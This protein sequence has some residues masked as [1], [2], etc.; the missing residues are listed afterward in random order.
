MSQKAIIIGLSETC[1][2]LERQ[3]DLLPHPPVTLGWVLAEGDSTN[4]AGDSP[5]G[6]R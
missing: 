4:A 6:R 2:R 1:R 5:S 3:L